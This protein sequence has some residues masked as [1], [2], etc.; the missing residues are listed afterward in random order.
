MDKRH[1]SRLNINLGAELISNNNSY[2]G[3]IENF[4]N[5][6]LGVR[7]APSEDLDGIKPGD[8]IIVKF[9]ANPKDAL[10]ISYRIKWLVKT[11]DPS[12]GS[13]YRMGMEYSIN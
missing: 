6:G 10:S 1:Y 4:S 11:D 9:Q 8:N 3:V 12:C 5:S 2:K 13:I 7:S